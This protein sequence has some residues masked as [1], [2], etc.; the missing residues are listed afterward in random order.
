[1]SLRYV[2][3]QAFEGDPFQNQLSF[4]AG[5]IVIVKDEATLNAMN[6]WGWGKLEAASQSGWFPSNYVAPAPTHAPPPVPIAEVVSVSPSNSCVQVSKDGPLSEIVTA[7]PLGE[8][9]AKMPSSVP[10]PIPSD[11]KDEVRNFFG[12][13]MGGSSPEQSGSPPVAQQPEPETFHIKVNAPDEAGNKSLFGSLR[14]TVMEGAHKTG[15]ALSSAASKTGEAL[16]S[17]TSRQTATSPKSTPSTPAASCTT[18]Q[19]LPNNGAQNSC[20]DSQEEGWF[21]SGIKNSSLFASRKP[22]TT[23]LSRKYNQSSVSPTECIA[24]STCSQRDTVPER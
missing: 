24:R 2:T 22:R 6:G 3:L 23:T 20:C 19:V 21:K 4:A 8:P 18:Q 5:E 1:M 15:S 14:S 17:M 16:S 11:E 9:T 10:P 12:P 7:I 13:I